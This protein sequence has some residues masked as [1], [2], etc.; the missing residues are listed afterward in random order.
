MA[1]PVRVSPVK[2][3]A[4]MPAWLVSSSPAEPGA[5]AVDHVV[6]AVR[7]A[8]LVHHLAEERRG[9]RCLLR[10]LDDDGV[11]GG[12]SGAHLPRHQE[13]RQVPR[14]DDRDHALR[15]AFCII[16]GRAAVGRGPLEE[17]RRHVLHHVGEDAEVGGAAGDVEV[18][19]ELSRLAGVGDLGVDEG[20][21][22]L[23]DAGRDG[24]EHLGALG[25]RELRPRPLHGPARGGDGGVD[26][27]SAGLRHLG[28]ERAVG[29][30]PILERLARARADV[31]PLDEVPVL[32]HDHLPRAAEYGAKN[33]DIQCE[34]SRF[35]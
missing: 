3:M 22:A 2:V 18:R 35:V 6:H 24:V 7:H 27:R 20:V 12:E 32:A 14:A 15:L 13:E 5:E 9:A 28:D 16:E 1:A 21:G 19:G 17:L 4:S 34:I 10:R 23:V 25:G 26:L 33:I 31:L 29:W 8:G 30:I 11:A